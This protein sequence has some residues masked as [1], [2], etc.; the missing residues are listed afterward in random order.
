MGLLPLHYL[1][2]YSSSFEPQDLQNVLS[3]S[4]LGDALS[5]HPHLVDLAL[6]ILTLSVPKYWLEQVGVSAPPGD[7]PLKDWIRDLVQRFAFIDRV[8][9]GGL[10]KT[11]T[12]WLGG[13][14]SPQAFLNVVQQV[15]PPKKLCNKVTSH[16][17][18]IT[19]CNKVLLF[20]VW[21]C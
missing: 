12:Y 2:R 9:T 18:Y 20:P 14:F 6:S 1:F 16:T 4:C 13:F 5:E 3:P 17:Q 10:A 7:W 21:T 15:T 8:L 11:P 19:E